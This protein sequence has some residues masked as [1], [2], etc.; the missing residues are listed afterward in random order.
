MAGYLDHYLKRLD[1]ILGDPS[2][3]ELAING[4]AGLWV[5][6]AGAAHMSRFDGI[7]MS[8][9]DVT[10]LARQI[11][12]AAEQ[13][14]T[15]ASPM[16][17]TTVPYGRATLRVQAIIAPAAFGGTVLS[18]RLFRQR[19]PSEAPKRF[20]FLRPQGI[21]L[22]TERLAKIE[23][24]QRLAAG[25]GL[26][27]DADALLKACIDLKLNL[28]LSGPTSAGKTELARRLIWMIPDTE[29]LVLIEDSA[30]ALPHQPNHVSLIAARDDASPRSADKLLQATLRLRPDR[31][32][33]GEV[34]GGEAATFLGAI[35]TGHEGS[36]TTLHA[37][38]GRKAM[39]KMALLVMNT[40]TQLSYREILRYLRGSIDAVIQTGREGEARGIMEVYVPAL[41]QDLLR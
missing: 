26:G 19:R 14:L 21:S 9:S 15:A 20:G 37:A 33:L 6:K 41:D 13:P 7:S 28:I 12:N 17:S 8:P 36:F 3:I 22:E 32:I 5:E 35:N 30:E 24:I 1:P 10:D 39:D 18:V 29:R 31:I 16:I 40:G 11:A 25:L 23:T 34:R 38:S 2:T 4:D 27:G